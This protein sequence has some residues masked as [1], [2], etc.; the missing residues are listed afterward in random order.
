V[1]FLFSR[2][3]LTIDPVDTSIDFI[4]ETFLANLHYSN[5]S[6]PGWLIAQ[7]PRLREIAGGATF[8]R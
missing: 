1:P 5:A 3:R 6:Q 8:T 4:N 2:P 7:Q